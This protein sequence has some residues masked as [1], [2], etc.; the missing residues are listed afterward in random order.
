MLNERKPKNLLNFQTEFV[1]YLAWHIQQLMLNSVRDELCRD[2]FLDALED[3]EF[4]VKVRQ[5]RP[6]F[7]DEA[8]TLASEV[9]AIEQSEDR[10]QTKA[11]YVNN[12]EEVLAV[13]GDETN[14]I[15]ERSFHIIEQNTEVMKEMLSAMKVTDLLTLVPPLSPRTVN[16]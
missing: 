10:K 15:F 3:R 7:L 2:Q 8:V 4:R 16:L 9:E 1:I 13:N 5:L 12:P 6:K 11:V 14:R